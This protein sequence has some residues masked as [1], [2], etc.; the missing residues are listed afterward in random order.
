MAH[1]KCFLH[2]LPCLIA[3]LLTALPAS[4]DSSSNSG[5]VDQRLIKPAVDPA[6][7]GQPMQMPNAGAEKI[8]TLPTLHNDLATQ[9]VLNSLAKQAGWFPD[10][11]ITAVEGIVTLKGVTKNAQQLQ[12]LATTVDRLPGVIAVINQT[13]LEIPPVTD[14]SPAWAEFRRLIEEAKKAIPLAII[15]LFVM[16]FFIFVSRYA[17][18]GV[19]AVWGR[20]I[21]NPFLL[22]T[23]SRLTMLPVWAIFFYVTLRTAGLSGLA[24]TLI[25]GTGAASLVVGFAFK[26]IAENYLSGLLLAIR[27]PFTKGDEI[28]VDKYAGFV[29][30]LNMRGTTI[31]DYD[32]NVILIPN[33]IVIQSVIRNR[34]TNSNTRTTFTITISYMNSVSKAQELIYSIV[35]KTPD[36]LVKPAMGV[37]VDKMSA[38][39]IDFI[40]SFWFDATKASGDRIKS[41]LIGQ[42]KDQLLANGFHIPDTARELVFADTLN[43]H[44]M[45]TTEQSTAANERRQGAIKNEAEIAIHENTPLTAEPDDTERQDIQDL[46]KDVDILKKSVHSGLVKA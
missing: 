16:A 29:Q 26:G 41:N 22:A 38:S 17:A 14:L 34:T 42:L 20:H 46:A 3:I 27:S 39:G 25:G 6:E 40:V 7:A 35:A 32:G 4:S 31:I 9:K 19:R 21:S 30:S 37:N 10:V 12:W 44:L 11:K 5:P 33:S 18:L 43:V 24:T 1:S 23:I 8:V 45:R 28:Q 13:Q 15:A 2:A 36:I